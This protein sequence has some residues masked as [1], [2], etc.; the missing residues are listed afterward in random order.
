MVLAKLKPLSVSAKKLWKSKMKK[1]L[2]GSTILTATAVLS[3]STSSIEA[4]EKAKPLQI[5]VGG[6]FNSVIGFADQSDSFENDTGTPG[7]EPGYD[8]FNIYNDS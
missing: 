1:V 3:L 7:L 8:S 4:Q 5:S 6:F 2:F